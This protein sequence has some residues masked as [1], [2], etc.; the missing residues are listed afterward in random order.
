MPSRSNYPR[1]CVSIGLPTPEAMLACARQD[2]DEGS[3]FFEFRLD[4]LEEPE[5]GLRAISDFVAEYP[6][7]RALATCRRQANHG[8]YAGD[9]ESQLRLLAGALK[10]GASAVDVEVES[11]GPGAA[12]ALEEIRRL[13]DLIISYHHFEATP[14]MEAVYRKLT[15]IPAKAYK[16]AVTARKPSDILR[17]LDVARNHRR[18]PLILLSMGEAGFP[19][20]V[21][22]PIF[23]GLFTYAAPSSATGTAPGQA[24]A[25]TLRHLYHIDTL[26]RS[27]KIYGVIADPVAHSISPAVHNRAF[28]ALRVDAVY[29]PFLV[30]P[31][32]LRDFFTLAERLPVRGFS[33]TIPHKQRVL[34]YLDHVDPLARRIGAVNTVWRKAGKWRGT[35]TDA[36]AVTGPLEKRLRLAGASVLIAGSGGAARAAAFAVADR[37]AKVSITGRS[38][39]KVRKLANLCRATPLS[40]E[41]A[42]EGN[43]DALVHA[44]PLGM[45]PETEG[46]FFDGR[47]PASVV[48]DMV[49]NPGE[50]LLLKRARDQGKTVISGLE[51]FVEQAARQFEIWT[52]CEAP[53]GVM[54][55]AAREA[56]N[57]G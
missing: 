12:R 16:I 32:Q 5:G 10:A 50:T 48:F 39:D 13:G 4:Y 25:R 40:R 22:A 15:R 52:G 7:C 49:Y 23:G 3:T 47:I 45:Y 55:R 26:S 44:T 28:H 41:E 30:A 21:I 35:N 34:R 57:A 54:E 24:S 19:A 51:M 36:P 14:A 43:F 11:A 2:A 53:A 1:I 38:M 46:C 31:T 27:T 18:T 9:V 37:G 56:L 29:V 42:A 8:R 33:V 17:L 20:R 6:E